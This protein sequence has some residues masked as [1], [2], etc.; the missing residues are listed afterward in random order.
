LTISSGA[1]TQWRD[2]SGSSN[3][4]T[5]T[6][7]TPTSI[8]DNGRSVVNFLSGAI[9]TSANQITFTTSSAFY[10]VSKMTSLSGA[11]ISMVVGFTNINDGDLTFVRYNPSAILNGTAAT[12]TNERDLG[13]NNYYVNGT[14][15]PSTFG[16]NFYL[17]VY[18][19]IGTVSPITS[20]TSFLTLS[21]SFMSRFFIG[22]IAEFL[23]YPGGIT[24]SQ[25]QQV[26]GYLAQKWGLR[27]NLPGG[28]PGITAIIYPTPRRTGTVTMTVNLRPY[29]TEFSLTSISGCQLWL[30][31]ADSSAV[32]IA[33][34][35][36]QWND[37]SGN[38]YNLT[39][40]MHRI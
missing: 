32:T 15:N 6:S 9:M 16:S 38:A 13:N 23:Y 5:P 24:S 21:S 37:K 28:H 8:S 40:G 19:I 31:A 18:S 7:G 26:E 1:I 30:D 35:V 2:K 20:G 11:T 17:N 10:I 33:T 12:S 22:N 14:F 29:Y 4:F 39:Q 36:S 27:N 34:G 25:R 3:H